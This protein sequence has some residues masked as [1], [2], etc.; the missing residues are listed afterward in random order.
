MSHDKP[1]N[2]LIGVQRCAL[3]MLGCWLGFVVFMALAMRLYPGGTW[4]DPKAPGHHF[5]ANFFCDLTQPT[6]LSGVDNHLGAACAQVGLLL[7]AAALAGFFWVLPGNFSLGSRSGPWVRALGGAAVLLFVAVALMPS[8]RFGLLHG[9]LA[10]TSGALGI[11]AALCA[12]VALSRSSSPARWLGRLG[13]CTLAVATFDALLFAYHLRDA[14]PPPLLLPAAQK[15]A[16]LLLSAWMV[17]TA[18]L[19]RRP[20]SLAAGVIHRP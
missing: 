18:W 10:L 17:G 7:F 5:F 9:S 4:L 11:G 3:F 8:E 2:G 15:V 19:I 12:V 14:A 1:M 20:S 6:S 16:A 13:A